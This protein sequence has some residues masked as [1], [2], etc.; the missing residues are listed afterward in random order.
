MDLVFR[1]FIRL[2][3]ILLVSNCCSYG[4]EENVSP[5]SR[6]EVPPSAS[7]EEFEEISLEE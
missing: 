1:L 2:S 6:S 4:F 7:K 5:P 3:H